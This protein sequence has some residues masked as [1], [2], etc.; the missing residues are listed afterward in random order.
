MEHSNID[1]KDF[2]EPIR[3]ML[4][5]L[6]IKALENFKNSLDR[7]KVNNM[8]SGVMEMLKQTMPGQDHQTLARLIDSLMAQKKPE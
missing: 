8:V 3:S 6:D 2:P 7:D 4:Q 1:L 5:S